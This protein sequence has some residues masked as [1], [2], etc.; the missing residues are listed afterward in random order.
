MSARHRKEGWIF[1]SQAPILALMH[2][3]LN[4]LHRIQQN[5]ALGERS[6]LNT[7]ALEAQ[8]FAI[9]KRKLAPRNSGCQLRIDNPQS[10]MAQTTSGH[11]FQ[12]ELIETVVRLCWATEH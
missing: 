10:S 3:V 11:K 4:N 9:A 1:F 5:V 12:K 8:K 6:N 7:T 2:F